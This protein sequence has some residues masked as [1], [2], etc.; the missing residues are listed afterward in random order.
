VSCCVDATIFLVNRGGN[1]ALDRIG[2]LD[3]K[4]EAEVV[5][6]DASPRRTGVYGGD[7]GKLAAASCSSYSSS[8]SCRF[9]FRAL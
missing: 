1:D 7:S 9:R 3:T 8:L 2:E 4:N 6:N 5:A